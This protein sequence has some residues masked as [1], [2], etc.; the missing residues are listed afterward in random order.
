[1]TDNKKADPESQTSSGPAKKKIPAPRNKGSFKKVF[2]IFVFFPSL[3]AAL[4]YLLWATDMYVS[5]SLFSVKGR[6]STMSL[7]ISSILGSSPNLSS[8]DSYVV[9][10]FIRS[11]DMLNMLDEK[12]DLRTHYQNP[13][14]DF[15]SR[16]SPDA[17]QEDF[18]KYWQRVLEVTFDS[19]KG[20]LKLRV[21]AFTPEMARQMADE[22][23]IKSEA[24]INDM[25]RRSHLDSLD[26][27]RKE[28]ALAEK[29]LA[30]ARQELYIFQIQHRELSPED[31]AGSRVQLVSQLELEL[32]KA[33]A[34]LSAMSSY[35]QEGSH[36]L[37][38]IRHRI[39]G[40]QKQIE[41][42]QARLTGPDHEKIADL[43]K[44]YQGL[45][46][47][48]EFAEKQYLSAVSSLES[49]RVQMEGK[50]GYIIPIQHPTL[51]QEAQHP[52]RVMAGFLSFCVI[53]LGVGISFL[54]ITAI[55]EHS[56]A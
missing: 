8:V 30:R 2:I 16:L 40:L 9:A 41:F 25:H 14:A 50:T 19:T 18:L 20:I 6:E 44:D 33:Q 54:V 48:Q 42:E 51:P 37:R 11:Q 3:V 1:M 38:S 17:S 29:R 22:I 26:Q 4:Y 36:E 7:D 43:I 49:A 32:A 15:I 34:E 13:D 23:L 10:D 45:I 12:F 31:R 5:E 39:G 27:A 47:E 21:R 55:R 56:G 28:V 35:M 24:L 52:R 53:F 46:L